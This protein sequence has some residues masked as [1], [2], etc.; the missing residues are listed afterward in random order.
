MVRIESF[1]PLSL[2]LQQGVVYFADD[3]NSYHLDLFRELR[4]IKTVGVLPVIDD[5]VMQIH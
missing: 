5:F 4:K 3:D 2:L 1:S